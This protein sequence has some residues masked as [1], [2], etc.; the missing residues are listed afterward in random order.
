MNIVVIIGI[1]HSERNYIS[2]Q[3]SINEKG[4]ERHERAW[5]HDSSTKPSVELAE[6]EIMTENSDE[7]G[8][9]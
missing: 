9:Y 6:T 5:S 2:Y 8:G 7:E 1:P 3:R 4:I